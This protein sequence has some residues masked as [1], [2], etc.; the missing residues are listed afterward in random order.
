MDYCVRIA[1]VVLAIYCKRASETVCFL[2][3]YQ[4]HSKII[5]KRKGTKNLQ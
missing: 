4:K 1:E 2:G 5:Q 3:F